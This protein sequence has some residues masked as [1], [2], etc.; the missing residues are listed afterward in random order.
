MGRAGYFGKNVL[1]IARTVSMSKTVSD[2]GTKHLVPYTIKSKKHLSKLNGKYYKED[3][4]D[5]DYKLLDE[6]TDKHL[7]GKTIYVRSAVTCCLG[8]HVCA[9]CIGSTAATN[10]DIADG[11]SAFDSEEV[12]KVVNQSILSTK[13]L[14]TTNSEVIEFN[15]E[16]HN[17][18]TIVGGE[19]NPL[20]N[21]NEDV[22]NIDDYAIYIDP[23]D[24]VKLEEQDYD[25]LYNNCISNGKFYIRNVVDS[26]VEDIVIQAEGEKEIFLTELALEAMRRGKGLIYFKDLNDDEKLFEMVIMNQ[27]LTKPLYQLM[28]LLNKQKADTV[29][30]T[31]ETMSEKFLD[32]LI[33]S[34][35]DANI[36]AG[37]LIINPLIRSMERPYE[38]PDFSKEELEPYMIYTVTKALEKNSS[39]LMGISF[40]N[41]K[42]QFLSDEL[43][44]ERTGTSYIDPFFQTEIP[45]DNLKIYAEIA[46]DEKKAKTTN[47]DVTSIW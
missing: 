30:E 5:I 10:L 18:F 14:L 23:E 28:D 3:L 45:T 12:T 2:C 43:Y 31:I 24:I 34:H 42:R 17:F 25:S 1:K 8:N 32:L 27:E 39:P 29:M 41:L 15:P 16:F 20:V 13:H 4:M 26:S 9:K 11:I 38:R 6:T 47:E 40:Q 35:I 7:M 44:E 22:P 19:I 36:I 46:A 33:E 37:E 21:D